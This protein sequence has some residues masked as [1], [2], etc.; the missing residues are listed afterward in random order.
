MDM[1][2]LKYIDHKALSTNIEK[3]DLEFALTLY[4]DNNTITFKTQV[5][6][7]LHNLTCF[8]YK[9]TVNKKY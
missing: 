7:S 1:L 4:K 5:H 8:K 9:T 6:F 2:L 3:I